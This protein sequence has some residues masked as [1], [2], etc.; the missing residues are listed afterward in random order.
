M[1]QIYNFLFWVLLLFFMKALLFVSDSV[2]QCFS[3]STSLNFHNGFLSHPFSLDSNLSLMSTCSRKVL[4][5]TFWEK[6][7][8]T[9]PPPR[10]ALANPKR[11]SATPGKRNASI[12]PKSWSW[13]EEIKRKTTYSKKMG[14]SLKR[15]L[16]E[17]L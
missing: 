11:D 5:V 1:F 9:Q 6:G 4:C 16:T 12:Y 2:W 3:S 13:L 8:I 17:I 7:P 14:I 10:F 15:K